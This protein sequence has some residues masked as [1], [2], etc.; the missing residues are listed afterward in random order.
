M[1]VRSSDLQST[2]NFFFFSKGEWW[3]W[4]VE[5]MLSDLLRVR[6]LVVTLSFYPQCAIHSFVRSFLLCP[7]HTKARQ[8]RTSCKQ[9]QQQQ[10]KESN[11]RFWLA[12]FSTLTLS[13]CCCR[14]VGSIHIKLF[15]FDI[16]IIPSFFILLFSPIHQT[17]RVQLLFR[18]FPFGCSASHLI[19]A[20][21][22]Q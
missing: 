6:C 7:P 10:K 16:I 12:T 17:W 2:P 5:L 20:H 1:A 22:T 14:P 9:Q 3:R 4:V 21:E 13:W 8:Q 18:I 19:R 11:N 15:Q